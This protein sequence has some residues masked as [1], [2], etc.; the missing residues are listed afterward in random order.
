M[1]TI[2]ALE[3]PPFNLLIAIGLASGAVDL[4]RTDSKHISRIRLPSDSTL[5][6]PSSSSSYSS[7]ATALS[8]LSVTGLGFHSDPDS[9][10]VHLF[11]V[12]DG[13]VSTFPLS[14]VSTASQPARHL[15]APLGAPAKCVTMSNMQVQGMPL[16]LHGVLVG[17]IWSSRIFLPCV[18]PCCSKAG[19]PLGSS[20][21][22]Y[23]RVR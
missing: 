14:N 1:T 20:V 10:A 16:C 21:N 5:P 6:Q 11:V 4:L 19:L 7:Q 17:P 13:G 2:A 23:S 22:V 3:A 18:L 8:R 9:S 12:S 15:M